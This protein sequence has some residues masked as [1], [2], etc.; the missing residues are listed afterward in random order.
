M[1]MSCVENFISREERLL[2]T[3][4]YSNSKDILFS[5]SSDWCAP[6][7]VANCFFHSIWKN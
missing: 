3:W 2:E 5:K 6:I 1:K 7:I 4:E